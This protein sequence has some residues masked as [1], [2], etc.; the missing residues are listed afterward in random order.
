M[1]AARVRTQTARS[2]VQRTYHE[3]TAPPNRRSAVG[4]RNRNVL[5]ER[6][7]MSKAERTVETHYMKCVQLKQTAKLN[8]GVK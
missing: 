3:A 8:H 7:R 1:S 4:V 6:T 2:G 5:G